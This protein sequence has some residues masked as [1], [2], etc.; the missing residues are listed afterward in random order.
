MSLT[1]RKRKLT[2]VVATARMMRDRCHA[3]GDFSLSALSASSPFER[4]QGIRLTDRVWPVKN[5]Q[6]ECKSQVMLISSGG[7]MEA[8]RQ[9]AF[10]RAQPRSRFAMFARAAVGISSCSVSIHF[11]NIPIARYTTDCSSVANSFFNSMLGTRNL[12][13]TSSTPMP[14]S[15][16]MASCFGSRVFPDTEL[17]RSFIPGRLRQA[18]AAVTPTEFTRQRR[19]L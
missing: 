18:D 17:L 15:P 1:G 11:R 8:I 19:A 2:S 7:C 14:H 5:A 10:V 4:H 3:S 9:S 6:N 12:T 13:P 16:A